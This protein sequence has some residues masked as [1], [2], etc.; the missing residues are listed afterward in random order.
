MNTPLRPLSELATIQ[1]G[2]PFL[3]ASDMD[4]GEP[5]FVPA[6]LHHDDELEPDDSMV[7]PAKLLVRPEEKYRL[8]PENVLITAKATPGNLRCG[9]LS[10][11][12]SNQ[13]LYAANLIR[14][15]ADSEKIHPRYLHAW[16]CHPEGRAAL[17]ATSQSTTG[18]LN[19]TAGA[20][21]NVMIPVPPWQ[22]Q[23]KIVE[24]LHT[25]ATAHHHAISAA[26]SRLN[27]A[28]EIAFQPSKP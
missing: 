18:Q 8:K 11:K 22:E 1:T 7:R 2:I 19:L 9:Y 15:H 14:V 27:L 5:V 13:W 26:E 21:G 25:A 3:T 28:R 10:A 17:I 12:W 16:F 6:A 4:K 20:L 24:L 23:I